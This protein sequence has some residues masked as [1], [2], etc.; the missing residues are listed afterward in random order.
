VN[1]LLHNPSEKHRS[2]VSK[3]KY[4]L[5]HETLLLPHIPPLQRNYGTPAPF[6][7]YIYDMPATFNQDIVR[8]NSK[9]A[10]SMFA[11]EVALHT[12]LLSSSVRTLDPNIA[13]FFYVPAYTTCQYTPFAGNGPDPWAGKEMMKKALLWIQKYHAKNWNR[14]QGSDHIFTATHDYASCFDFQRARANKIGPLKKLSNSIVL[15]SLGDSASPC[16][17]AKK[18]VVVPPVIPNRYGF[19]RRERK[20]PSSLRRSAK[21]KR[22]KKEEEMLIQG[23]IIQANWQTYVGE[24][25]T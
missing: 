5:K 4:K 2:L 9:C 18:D 24:Q 21:K 10:S 14:K 16:Y 13:D 11:S 12:W 7:I 6:K 23:E 25:G 22:K 1:Q 17:H 19:P 15:M 8:D 20:N 3:L